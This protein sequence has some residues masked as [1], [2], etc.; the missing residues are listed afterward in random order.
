MESVIFR[1]SVLSV[2]QSLDFMSKHPL[3]PPTNSRG[4]I[5]LAQHGRL[6]MDYHELLNLR[7]QVRKAEMAA[8]TRRP[9]RACRHMPSKI[10]INADKKGW[11]H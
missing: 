10:Q 7:E 6:E 2:W 8:A 4:A 1:A 5:L 9:S 11:R 3:R